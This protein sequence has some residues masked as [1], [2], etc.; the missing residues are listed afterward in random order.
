M[1][2][3]KRKAN[4]LAIIEGSR[5]YTIVANCGPVEHYFPMGT[6]VR[7]TMTPGEPNEFIEVHKR[8]NRYPLVQYLQANH[9]I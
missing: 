4:K 9:Y 3:N 5:R 8:P 2:K 1:N 6:V 7:R